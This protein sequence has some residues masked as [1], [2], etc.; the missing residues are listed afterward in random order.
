MIRNI[1]SRLSSFILVWLCA[2][3][4]ER[5][6]GAPMGAMMA[7]A[8]NP[9]NL[10]H[11]IFQKTS[12]VRYPCVIQNI[13]SRLSSFILVWL[14]APYRKRGSGAPKGAMMALA[15]NVINMIHNILQ[16]IH[17]ISD[18]L[19]LFKVLSPGYFVTLYPCVA[20]CTL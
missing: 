5:V 18:I 17:P 4:S 6:S 9:I 11:D 8:M 12:D 7:A 15:I 20:V 19:V 13:I 3:Y 14:C 16:K 2:P 1:I 10:V